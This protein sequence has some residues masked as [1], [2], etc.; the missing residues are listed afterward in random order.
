MSNSYCTKSVSGA[1]DID[2]VLVMISHLP[3]MTCSPNDQPSSV[4]KLK[5]IASSQRYLD[6]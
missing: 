4:N 5:L 1:T 6:L 3:V 2:S